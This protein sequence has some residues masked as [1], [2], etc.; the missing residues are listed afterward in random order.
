MQTEKFHEDL[1]E[2]MAVGAGKKT[3]IMCAEAVPWKCHRSLI[4]N[5]FATRGWEV[6]H[7]MSER[8]ADRHQLTSF[9]TVENGRLRYV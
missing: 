5:V 6:R 3:V 4:A 2:L 7:L 8:K 1:E 9:A